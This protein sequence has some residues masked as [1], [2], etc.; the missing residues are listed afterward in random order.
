MMLALKVSILR[1]CSR[2]SGHR[3]NPMNGRLREEGDEVGS[4]IPYACVQQVPSCCVAFGWERR[5]SLQRNLIDCFA[6]TSS[7]NR[8]A[9]R[10]RSRPP[11]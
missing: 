1:A 10:A 4:G 6:A 5:C 9:A 11:N 8:V 7:R 2:C 3:V